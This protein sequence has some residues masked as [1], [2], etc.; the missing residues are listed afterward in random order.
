MPVSREELLRLSVRELRGIADQRGLN[1]TGLPEK[2]DLADAILHQHPTPAQSDRRDAPLP[3]T[4]GKVAEIRIERADIRERLGAVFGPDMDL[5]RVEAQGPA[6]RGGLARCLGWKAVAIDNTEVNNAEQLRNAVQG[7]L[8]FGV[9]LAAPATER[10]MI[11]R[12]ADPEERVGITFLPGL[13]IDTV[14]PGGPADRAGLR[15]CQ[16]WRVG[17]VDGQ[18]VGDVAGLSALLEGRMEW[19]LNLLVPKDDPAP[20]LRV[21]QLP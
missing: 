20:L 9:R 19:T 10:R 11:M 12:R 2:S 15:S 4:Q 3:F 5:Q 16:C 6:R 1:V 14:H 18:S 8:R 13:V 7:R 17:G 21:P